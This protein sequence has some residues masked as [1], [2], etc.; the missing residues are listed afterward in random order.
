MIVAQ[1]MNQ[2]EFF[3]RSSYIDA[4]Q[5]HLKDIEKKCKKVGVS[6][7]KLIIGEEKLFKKYPE[8]FSACE[9]WF[10]AYT[11]ITVE[12]E[13]V[14][15][16][17]GWQ[18]AATVES[19]E[20][21]N[22]VCGVPEL[23]DRLPHDLRTAKLQCEHCK[24]KRNRK[25]HI[26]ILSESGEVKIVGSTCLKDFLAH[27]VDSKISLIEAELDLFRNLSDD[28]YEW[29]GGNWIEPPLHTAIAQ[30][31][32]V[33]R[34]YPWV[35]SGD[36]NIL[37]GKRPT[38]NE[39]SNQ[40]WNPRLKSE[41]KI[42]ITQEDEDR[43]A[44]VLARWEQTAQTATPEGSEFDWKKKL[45]FERGAVEPKRIALVIGLAYG[46]WCKIQQEIEAAALEK[47]KGEQDYFG[48]EGKKGKF[49]ITILKAFSVP[50]Y[51]G[52]SELVCGVLAGTP[53]QFSWFNSGVR[54]YDFGQTYTVEATVKSHE[55]TERYG[56]QTKLNRVKQ[57]T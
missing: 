16:P 45:L 27:D 20:S 6:A 39:V 48:E 44:Q 56:K 53:H 21:G 37:A 14:K 28:G 35:R 8:H 11:H 5:K 43:A 7:P 52:A 9:P 40:I 41:E 57:L 42:C 30:M 38:H 3:I 47:I 23:S 15:L 19:Y 10:E 4:V 12:W 22:M 51:G 2:Q 54:W 46:E 31:F 25:K 1:E 32:A 26:V 17:G 49:Q 24:V 55:E 36:S 50:G 34:K 33:L 13:D 29:G 18:F